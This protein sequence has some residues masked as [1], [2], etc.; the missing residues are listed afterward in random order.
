M[1]PKPTGGIDRETIQ[2]AKSG[3]EAAISLIVSKYQSYLL[4]IANRQLEPT[5]AGRISPSD[6]VQETVFKL[7]EKIAN[8]SGGSELELKA[9]LRVCLS[10]TVK[11]TRR[12][13][14]QE[15]RSVSNET[16]LPSSR[17]E[18]TGTPSKLLQ[19]ME[20]LSGLERGLKELSEKD[21]QVLRMR[22]EEGLTFVE[23]GEVLRISTD[24]ARMAW[25][26][27]IDR[28]KTHVSKYG[29]L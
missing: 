7:P 20:R 18:D 8:F 14:R 13:H 9:W 22:H 11:N 3:D 29:D 16:N 28:L 6:V 5:L 15:K 1:S 23:I 19:T 25:G 17:F 2:L 10:N 21:Q 4:F 26:R 27:A 12:F 24:A